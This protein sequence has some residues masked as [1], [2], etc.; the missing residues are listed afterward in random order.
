LERRLGCDCQ[1]LGFATASELQLPT[2]LPDEPL[3]SQFAGPLAL[4]LTRGSPRVPQIDFLD[5]RKTVVKPDNRGKQL[6]WAGAA[7][8]AL[9]AS[10]LVGHTWRL[11]SLDSEI[12]SLRLRDSQL[13]AEIKK[14]T[15]TDESVALV[16]KWQG[17]GV[18]WLRQ[19]A[20]LSQRMPATDRLYLESLQLVH[21]NNQLPKIVAH[22]YAREQK[23]VRELSS[24]L[25]TSERYRVMPYQAAK[26]N[27]DSY[28]PWKIDGQ[29]IL[30]AAPAKE[31][32]SAAKPAAGKGTPAPGTRPQGAPD[33]AEPGKTEPAQAKSF[34]SDEPA[35]RTAVA[36]RGTQAEPRQAGRG[37]VAP[38]ATADASATTA[39]A[40]P[41][42]RPQ[43]GTES[44]AATADGRR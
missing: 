11:W 8:G 1:P 26:S 3:Q 20:D 12:E 19:L 38:V 7:A 37:P 25:H 30:L 29:E 4:L 22:G 31:S 28:Y 18:D 42:G 36:P 2:I 21:T 27:A 41:T 39:P 40:A 15:P 6:K 34:G 43:S 24:G 17:E 10:L 33:Q 44:P 23:D 32:K 35:S 14:S 9:A 16:Q 5:P 13:A